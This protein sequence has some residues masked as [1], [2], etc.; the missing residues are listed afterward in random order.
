[1]LRPGLNVAHEALNRAGAQPG[2]A[3]G[4]EGKIAETF[5]SFDK[6]AVKRLTAQGGS[7]TALV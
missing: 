2:A 6:K 1:V 5:V 7:A 4:A 3:R